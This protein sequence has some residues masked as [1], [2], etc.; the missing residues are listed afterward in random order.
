[1]IEKTVIQTRGFHNISDENGNITGFQ[2][3]IAHR[4]YRG[5]YLSQFRVGTITVDDMSYGNDDVTFEFYGR[6]YTAEELKKE[7]KVWWQVPDVATIKIKKSGGLS[8]GFHDITVRFGWICNYI[9]P[10]REDPDYGV[11][12]GGFEHKKRL[13]I[14]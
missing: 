2:F 8:Q 7:G 12:F 6:E 14:V 3:C 9:G 4:Y 11:N 5:M 10:D 13:I 1:M